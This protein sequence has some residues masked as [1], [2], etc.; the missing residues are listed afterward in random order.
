MPR[1]PASGASAATRDSI[2]GA[3]SIPPRP[4]GSTARAV[5]P[6]DVE[7]RGRAAFDRAQA[8][9]DLVTSGSSCCRSARA[10]AKSRRMQ[11]L[12]QVMG[13]RRR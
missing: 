1:R 7:Q 4:A 5:E 9:V 3:S 6:R 11:R 13:W 12:Q 2:S 10:E 8:L